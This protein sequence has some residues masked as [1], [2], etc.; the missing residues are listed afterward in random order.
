MTDNDHNWRGSTSEFD[1]FIAKY[2]SEAFRDKVCAA[3]GLDRKT[4]EYRLKAYLVEM[5]FGYQFVSGHLEN[6][7]CRILEVGAGL[8][9]LSIF[10]SSLGH[11]VCALQPADDVFALFDTT[12][13]L[14]WQDVGHDGPT[15]LEIGAEDLSP[16]EHGEFDLIFSVNVMEHIAP[17]KQATAA[18][19]SVLA[20]T[21]KCVNLCPN[22]TIP[23]EPHYGLVM[24]PFSPAASR[25]LWRRRLDQDPDIWNTLNFIDYF[26][27]RKM[28]RKNRAEVKF[29]KAVLYDSF[30]RLG[31][32]AAFS[33]RHNN[34]L[35]G[36]VYRILKTTRLLALTKYIPVAFSTPMIFT[37]TKK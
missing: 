9:L 13:K 33:V 28:A 20:D 1:A 6:R 22:Y 7:K 27:V 31:S 15:H 18:I 17:I 10:L 12:K 3:S 36:R 21:G 29:Q 24:V 19:L 34:T 11:E 4:V 30:V 8:G 25:W 35:V 32:D 5:R 26:D 2:E 16:Q 23:Y 37:Y 14:I